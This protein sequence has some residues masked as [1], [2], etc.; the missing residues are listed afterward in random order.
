MT[1]KQCI[2]CGES[3]VADCGCGALY[4]VSEFK[5]CRL[6]HDIAFTAPPHTLE[7]RQ[8]RFCYRLLGCWFPALK[9]VT[10]G[11]YNAKAQCVPIPQ[12]SG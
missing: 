6:E 10:D 3:I 4:S 11:K 8:C 1:R 5:E 9:G 2:G 7:V 12:T